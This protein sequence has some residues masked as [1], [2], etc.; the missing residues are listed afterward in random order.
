MGK[1]ALI[2]GASGD[3]GVAI[4]RQIASLGYQLILHYHKN[5]RAI[6]QIAATTNKD[7]IL[8]VIQADLSDR[9]DLQ[10]FVRQLV[11]P[12]DCIIFTSGYAHFGLF[13]S[14]SE[15][16]MDKMMTLHVKAPWLI[17]KQ[18]LPS[19]IQKQSGAIILIT[20]IWGSIGASY[21]VLY[22]SV[23]GAQNSFI[24][25]L[26]KEVAPS[27]I[28]VNGISPGFIDTKM[29]QHLDDEERDAVIADIPMQRAGTAEEI[30]HTVSFLLDDKAKYIQGE[31]I[32]V[33]G[34]W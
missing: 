7:C 18:V 32:Q 28:S 4:S 13:Q 15:E 31:I 11:F 3:I 27:G 19:M 34:G 30:A 23:K 12:V 16:V 20:S 21:E 26:A 17:T 14:V 24:K 22:S 6:E 25:A 9:A 33:T 8:D 1:N 29:N 5:K 2:V 10:R